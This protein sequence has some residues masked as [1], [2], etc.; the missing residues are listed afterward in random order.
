MGGE[1]QRG[2]LPGSEHLWNH[3]GWWP[4][5]SHLAALSSSFMLVFTMWV[6]FLQNTRVGD[7]VREEVPSKYVSQYPWPHSH[8]IH[9]FCGLHLHVALYYS[10]SS[11]QGMGGNCPLKLLVWVSRWFLLWRWPDIQ[12]IWC[13]SKKI[14]SFP[15]KGV[16]KVQIQRPQ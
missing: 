5:L 8:N 3:T 12:A 6:W 2:S 13:E 7:S 15:T 11:V 10:P 4:E 9:A 1:S 16:A 14:L